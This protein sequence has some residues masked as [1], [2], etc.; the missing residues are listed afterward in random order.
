MSRWLLFATGL[1]LFFP[2]TA[3]AQVFP[4]SGKIFIDAYLPTDTKVE[5]KTFQQ[6]SSSLWLESNPVFTD[7]LG[8]KWIYQGDVFDGPNSTVSGESRETH[9]ESYL[10]EGYVYYRSGG[11]DLR[12]GQQIIPW[13]KSD[14]INP[15]DFLTSKNSTFFNPDDEV[16]RRGSASVLLNFTPEEGA[17]PWSFTTVW[18]TIF[19]RSKHLIA[20]QSVPSNVTL[21]EA[22]PPPVTFQNGEISEKISYT[23][24]GWDGSLSYFNGWSHKPELQ[25]RSHILVGFTPVVEVDQ[26]FRRVQGYG[27]DWSYSTEKWVYRFESAYIVTA[28]HDGENPLVMPTHWDSVLGAERPIG[29]HFR[30]QG[31]FIMRYFPQFKSA[32]QAGGPDAI[33]AGVNRSLASTNALLLGYQEQSQPAGSVR[34][35]YTDQEN[36]IEADI[37]LLQNFNGSDY[38]IRPKISYGWTD[39]IRSTVGSEI[40]GGPTNRPLG[41]LHSYNSVFF[42]T[43]YTF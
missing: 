23:G 22:E 7:E 38:L 29:D 3:V 16:K 42:E 8:S 31:Q 2:F 41:S 35:S 39:F 6:L 40:Y 37:F 9:L 18:T 17:S 34:V 36:A 30:I 28:N 15:T 5:N 14:G 43:K 10:R 13:G 1:L 24:S 27:A 19:A 21:R 4:L 26:V 32:D 11:I 33:S 25:E 20:G 12:V